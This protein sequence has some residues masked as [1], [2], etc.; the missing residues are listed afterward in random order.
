MKLGPVTK[1]NKRNKKT[2]TKMKD[3]VMST[4]CGVTAVFSIYDQFSAI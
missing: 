3:D 1:I 2:T 4:N